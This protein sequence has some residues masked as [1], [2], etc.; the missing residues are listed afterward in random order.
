M[1]QVWSIFALPSS[2]K[3]S[4]IFVRAAYFGEP[5]R[6]KHILF[7]NLFYCWRAV[8]NGNSQSADGNS[9]RC[10]AEGVVQWMKK[11]L[12]S[13]ICLIQAEG[14]S[15][16]PCGKLGQLLVL[17]PT[18]VCD[19]LVFACCDATSIMY[20][21]CLG[22][23]GNFQ[24]LLSFDFQLSRDLLHARPAA[25][26]SNMLFVFKPSDDKGRHGARVEPGS[27]PQT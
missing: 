1:I 10:T 24:A 15:S 20:Q 22:R 16:I 11:I 7:F 9:W 27:N 5:G 21:L 13:W 8:L 25:H 6:L 26:G 14:T 19:S 2:K 18:S 23:Q 17:S 12:H 3:S 4:R